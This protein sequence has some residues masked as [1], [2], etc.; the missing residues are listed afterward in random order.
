ML[1]N[2]SNCWGLY[3][4]L[5]RCFTVQLQIEEISRK[6]R[7]GDLGIPLNPEER[8]EQDLTTDK[9]TVLST[10]STYPLTNSATHSS[11]AH[12]S[13]LV[14]VAVQVHVECSKNNSY[15]NQDSYSYFKY[16]RIN[17]DK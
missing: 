5:I 15:Y 8:F 10:K 12:Y 16:Q 9:M 14:T 3:P 11:V 7:T 6:L 1:N 2:N 13:Y 4:F 17:E